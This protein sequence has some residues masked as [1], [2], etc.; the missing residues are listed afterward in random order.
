MVTVSPDT[1]YDMAV[2]AS[3]YICF[4]SAAR[5]VNESK[6]ENK[7]ASLRTLI[8][9]W[10]YPRISRNWATRT[11]LI[12]QYFRYIY[13]LWWLR[14]ITIT[15]LCP[16]EASGKF[17]YLRTHCASHYFDRQLS[18]IL[19]IQKLSFF[20]QYYTKETGRVILLKALMSS[21][22]TCS[23]IRSSMIHS[24]CVV[25]YL[26]VRNSRVCRFVHLI[27][28]CTKTKKDWSAYCFFLES[29]KLFHLLW[30]GGLHSF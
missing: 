28:M 14:P 13:L 1:A 22:G 11:W 7:S 16:Y 29:S 17:Y 27:V 18:T 9:R 25:L 2:L 8:R 10:W 4:L 6:G 23:T 24:K 19:L 30:R 20:L 5:P 12:T 15:V 26:T 3:W 21:Q